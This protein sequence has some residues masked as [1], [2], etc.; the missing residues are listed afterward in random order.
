LRA[1]VIFTK[2][3]EHVEGFGVVGDEGGD[4]VGFGENIFQVLQTFSG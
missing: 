3:G 2:L 1:S 4:F